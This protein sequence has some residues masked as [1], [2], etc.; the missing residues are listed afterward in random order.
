MP[1]P[2]SCCRAYGGYRQRCDLLVGLH[3]LR[4]IGVDRAVD[5]ALRVRVKSEPEPMGCQGGSFVETGPR[6]RRTSGGAV[7][8]RGT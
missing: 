5:G 2:T 6:H 4:L 3:G 7:E 1:E 8:G